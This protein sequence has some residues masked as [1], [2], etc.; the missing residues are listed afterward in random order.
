[1]FSCLKNSGSIIETG[2]FEM[3]RESIEKVMHSDDEWRRLLTP[4]QFRIAREKGTEAPFT[5]KYWDTKSSGIYQCAACKL[6]L[7]SS[8]HKYDSGTGWPSY[9]QPVDEDHVSTNFDKSL[10]MVRTEVLCGRCG[11][12]LGHVFT[13][14]PKP[15]GLRYCINSGV[16]HLNESESRE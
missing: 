1:M 4:D 15:T 13:D 14:G 6:E 11:A 12:H 7:F 10:L 5:G 16:L 9:W 8:D 2:G 3:K